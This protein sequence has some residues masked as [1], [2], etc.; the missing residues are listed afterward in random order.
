[1]KEKVT[2]GVILRA[3]AERL[4]RHIVDYLTTD[5][6][7]SPDILEE[8]EITAVKKYYVSAYQYRYQKAVEYLYLE[9]GT[10]K[11]SSIFFKTEQFLSGDENYPEAVTA[12]YWDNTIPSEVPFDLEVEYTVSMQELKENLLQEIRKRI[13]QTLS[14]NS[15]LISISKEAQLL[16]DFIPDKI[17]VGIYEIEM[18]IKNQKYILFISAGGNRI[19]YENAPVQAGAFEQDAQEIFKIKSAF[20]KDG[21]KL[22]GYEKLQ[23]LTEC[24]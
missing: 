24:P 16:K 22:K 11:K 20:K 6:H 3:K 18:E 2:H 15:E 21:R 7:I 23:H 12:L 4:H 19:Y 13:Q 8:A 14:E 9:N 1:M 5:T 17:A 10:E